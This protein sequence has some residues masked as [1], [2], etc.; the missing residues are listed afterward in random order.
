MN[1]SQIPGFGWSPAH[2]P[3]ADI[4]E[5]LPEFRL[6]LFRVTGK[7]YQVRELEANS[8]FWLVTHT[9]RSPTFWNFFLNSDFHSSE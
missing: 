9:I 1:L 5:F 4:L 7:P 2:H 8:R 6:S 3:I